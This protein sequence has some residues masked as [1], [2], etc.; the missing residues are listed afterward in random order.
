M[1]RR[2][3]IASQSAGKT[4]ARMNITK[5]SKIG[6]ST[7]PVSCFDVYSGIRLL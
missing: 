4:V 2:G 3:L 5:I 6:H 7:P 1:W